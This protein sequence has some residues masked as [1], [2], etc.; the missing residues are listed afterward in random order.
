MLVVSR[1][2]TATQAL[3]DI[4]QQLSTLAACPDTTEVDLQ[5]LAAL[6]EVIHK[7]VEQVNNAACRVLVLRR[8]KAGEHV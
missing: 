2:L 3:D 5:H 7:A 4:R 1:I 6:D 8:N